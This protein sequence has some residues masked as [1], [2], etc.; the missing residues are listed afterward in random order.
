MDNN[1]KHIIEESQIITSYIIKE[2]KNK[3]ISYAKYLYKTYKYMLTDYHIEILK[4][5]LRKKRTT[6][7]KA[8]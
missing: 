6:K 3:N 1:L 4:K 8:L 5:T 7:T 2:Y